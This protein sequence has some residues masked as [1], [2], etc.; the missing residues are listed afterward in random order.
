[1]ATELPHEDEERLEKLFNTLDRDGNGRID[2]HDLSEALREFGLSSVHA[3][4]RLNQK[5]HSLYSKYCTN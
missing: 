3:E 2:I 5:S 1:M 4:V